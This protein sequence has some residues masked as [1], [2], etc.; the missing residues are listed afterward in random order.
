MMPQTLLIVAAHPDD[1]VLGCAGTVA[2]WVRAGA[3]A[4]V[5]ILGEGET[6]RH[7]TR[8][9]G[10]S[11]GAG[12]LAGLRRAADDAARVLGVASV[13]V[14]A[15]PDN[16]F[17]TVA[18][19]DLVKVVEAR[20]AEVRPDTV[21]THHRS[22]GNIDHQRTFAA[23]LTACRPLPG[24][25]VRALL[26]FETPSA[27]EWNIPQTFDPRVFIDISET[28]AVK[29]EALRAYAT[30]MR[31]WPHPRSHDGLDA[32]AAWRGATVGVRAA[33]AFEVIRMIGL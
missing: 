32:L 18:L 31:E 12:A 29:H 4:H 8:D 10:Q 28:L 7:A 6:S 5:T 24:R 2:T 25:T 21:L 20:I 15:F 30:E 27:T 17:D 3:T 33:E 14:E 19:L 22:D 9:V 11:A 16:R 26:S 13:R 1:E 23:V